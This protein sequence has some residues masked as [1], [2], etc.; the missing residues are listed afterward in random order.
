MSGLHFAMPARAK[1][2]W[3]ASRSVTLF[4]TDYTRSACRPNWNTTNSRDK[5][6]VDAV[7]ALEHRYSSGTSLRDGAAVS[8]ETCLNIEADDAEILLFDVR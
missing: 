8:D 3:Q 2:V 5:R 1:R 7:L 4:L 6:I